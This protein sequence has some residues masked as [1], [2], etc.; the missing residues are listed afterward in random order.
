MRITA[1]TTGDML[2]VVAPKAYLG[3][4]LS[5]YAKE[6]SFVLGVTELQPG[7]D[8][9][10]RDFILE[11]AGL[12]AEFP[13]TA[14]ANPAPKPRFEKYS[15]ILKEPNG[16]SVFDFQKL[17]NDLSAIKI[18][19]TYGRITGVIDSISMETAM[20]ASINSL[21][22]VNWEEQCKCKKG[23][24]GIQCEKCASGFTREN[25]KDGQYGK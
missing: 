19:V 22:S 11:G 2:Y 15:F 18:R 3:N 16:M 10:K 9:I 7:W 23:Y 12:K 20:P 17:L 21:Q 1:P 14:Q 4:R 24:T 8:D 6:F 5:S 25:N 13:I